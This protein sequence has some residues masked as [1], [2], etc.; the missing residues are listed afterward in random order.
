MEASCLMMVVEWI[1][2]GGW[3]AGWVDDGCWVG[4]VGFVREREREREAVRE[5]IIKNC[6]IMNIL[7]DKCVE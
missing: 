6:K 4:C 2:D 5:R 1:N 7:L 3:E